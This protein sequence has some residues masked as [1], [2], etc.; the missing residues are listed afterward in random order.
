[1]AKQGI[2]LLNLGTPDSPKVEDVKRYLKQFLNDPDVI[3]IPWLPRKILVNGVIVPK[4]A[5]FSAEEYQ[6]LFDM[7]DGESPL[8]FHTESLTQKVQSR[9]PNKVVRFA[10]RYGNPS[11]DK[12]LNEMYALELEEITIIPLYP[13]YA[14]ATTGS[15]IKEAERIMKKWKKKPAIKYVKQ[16]YSNE[17]FLES[18]VDKT[19]E[20]DVADYDHIL[21]SY[22]G[23]PKRQL[24]KYH[25]GK[26]CNELECDPNKNS[27]NAFCYR[28]TCF[29][30]SKLLA[31]KLKLDRKDYTVAFQSRLGKTV[32]TQPYADEAIKN[33]AEKGIKKLLVFSPAFTADCLETVLEIGEGYDELFKEHGGE[34]FT[35]VESLND[36]DKWVDCI[37]DLVQ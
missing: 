1:M 33:L 21:F 13:Q 6:K 35:L 20:I 3:D 36:S 23:L 25:N 9:Y 29:G 8:L 7:H 27:E 11:M 4:R 18:V 30:T 32:W 14:E 31:D 24:T 22:H 12:V 10:M 17:L 34:Q 26:E 28:A 16:F 37:T 5:P 19:T 15:T 2:L